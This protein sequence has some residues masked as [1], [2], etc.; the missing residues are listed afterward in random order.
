LLNL[1]SLVAKV[2]RSKYFPKESFITYRL[3]SNPSYVWRSLWGAKHLVQ[4][5]MLW[6]VGDGK[7]VK[8]WGDKWIDSTFLGK[9]QVPVRILGENDKVSDLIDD[10]TH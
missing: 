5:E 4:A 1:E 10:T 8:I 6:R 2:L 7:S 9:I 3:G